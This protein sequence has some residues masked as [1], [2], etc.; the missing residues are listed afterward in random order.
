[1]KLTDNLNQEHKDKLNEFTQMLGFSSFDSLMPNI[2]IGGGSGGMWN[3]LGALGGWFYEI[4]EMAEASGKLRAEEA[5]RKEVQTMPD[6][7][8]QIKGA[9]ISYGASVQVTE[10]IEQGVSAQL[11]LYVLNDDGILEMLDVDQDSRADTVSREALEKKL[12][13]GEFFIQRAE[14][15]GDASVYFMHNDA[16]QGFYVG[17]DGFDINVIPQNDLSQFVHSVAVPS[18]A[19]PAP[20]VAPKPQSPIIQYDTIKPAGM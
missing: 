13:G 16:G 11:S 18:V 3:Q 7:L 20:E 10:Q 8:Q 1:M 5:L 17:H 2:D 14:I 4:C 12:G 15:G 6:T 19:A 9:N